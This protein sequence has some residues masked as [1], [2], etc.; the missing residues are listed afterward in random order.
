M[1]SLLAIQFTGCMYVCM[2]VCMCE[3]AAGDP[4]MSADMVEEMRVL[5]GSAAE[6]E[7]TLKK[8]SRES[9]KMERA[10]KNQVRTCMYCMYV[11]MYVLFIQHCSRFNFVH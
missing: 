7:L 5:R 1:S 3:V 4:R 9:E 11:C 6:L 2:Y 10:L 8:K